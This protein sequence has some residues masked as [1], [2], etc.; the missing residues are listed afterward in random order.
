MLDISRHFYPKDKIIE[1]LD[2]LS[3]LK[4]NYFE[5]RLTDDEGWRIEI[6]GLPELTTVGANRGYTVNERDKLIPAYGSGAHGTK[7][8]NGYLSKKDFKEILVYANNL[9]IKVI[10]QISFPS[11]ARSAIKAMEARYFNYMKLGDIEK[12]NEY[13]LTDFIFSIKPSIIDI[14]PQNIPDSMAFIVFFPTIVEFLSIKGLS[15]IF[16]KLAVARYRDSKDKFTPGAIIP[17]L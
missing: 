6:P 4:L 1:V 16:G 9:G 10:P 15:E 8:G 13:L 3:L 2:I 5:L 14:Y 11:H 17:P 7:N 12:A